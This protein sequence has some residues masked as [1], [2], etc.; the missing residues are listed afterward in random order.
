MAEGNPL[1]VEELLRGLVSDRMD[2]PAAGPSR[3]EELPVPPAVR[4]LI[5]AELDVLPP[6]ERVVLELASVLGR[7]F[8]WATVATLAP[9]PLC[10]RV[11][12][13]LLALT[14]RNLLRVA[15][16]Q[17]GEGAFAFRHELLR[18]AAYR[19]I[20]KRERLILHMRVAERLAEGPGEAAAGGD[21]VVGYHLGHA[22]RYLSRLAGHELPPLT[23]LVRPVHDPPVGVTA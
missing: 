5:E 21:E 7:V 8:N 11:G 4:A 6:E 12:S 2:R 13:L 10:P 18:D 17:L 3:L 1:V 23:P 20:P 22:Y 16:Q 9:A 14:G 15:D 19:S